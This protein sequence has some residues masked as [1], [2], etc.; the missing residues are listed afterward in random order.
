MLDATMGHEVVNSGAT[1]AVLAA[2]MLGGANTKSLVPQATTPNAT[3][4]VSNTVRG[5]NEL[6]VNVRCLSVDVKDMFRS[7]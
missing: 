6:K 2:G 5:L 7:I 3:K 4:V 1:M